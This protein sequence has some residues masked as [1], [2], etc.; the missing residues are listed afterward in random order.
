MI[1]FSVK[2]KPFRVACLFCYGYQMLAVGL[3]WQSADVS[4]RPVIGIYFAQRNEYIRNILSI[5]SKFLG[6][7]PLSCSEHL[8]VDSG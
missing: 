6:F 8:V 7:P 1:D 3:G 2:T 5:P 4:L